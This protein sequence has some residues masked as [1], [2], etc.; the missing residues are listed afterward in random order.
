MLRHLEAIAI[1]LVLA[2][3]ISYSRIMMVTHTGSYGL[4]LIEVSKGLGYLHILYDNVTAEDIVMFFKDDP[5]VVYISVSG[6]VVYRVE[7]AS[8]VTINTVFL[9]PNNSFL[10]VTVGVKY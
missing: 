1:V 5:S 9:L 10:V 2:L 6:T 8:Y 4:R 3:F 7:G